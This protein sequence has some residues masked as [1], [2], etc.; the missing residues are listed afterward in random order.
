MPRRSRSSRR[1]RT[2]SAPARNR[3]TSWSWAPPHQEAARY[4]PLR[5]AND[6]PDWE[7][8]DM[9][10]LLLERGAQLAPPPTNHRSLTAAQLAANQVARTGL[11]LPPVPRRVAAAVAPSAVGTRLLGEEEMGARAFAVPRPL[12]PN[13]EMGLPRGRKGGVRRR[14]TRR[15]RSRRRR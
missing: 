13:I 5:A 3:R 6:A 11:S 14:K 9:S 4:Q 12:E 2:G 10:P 8:D 7:N 15:G 1:R